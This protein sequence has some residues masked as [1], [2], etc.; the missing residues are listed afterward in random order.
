[1]RLFVALA[2]PED[3][4]QRLHGLQR[5]L[6]AAKWVRPE[7]LHLTLRFIGEV[8]NGQAEDVDAVLSRVGGEPFDLAVGGLG[9][10]G[11]SRKIRA[12]WAGCEVSEPLVRLQAKIERALQVAGLPPEGRKF[13]P[14]I[15]LA[16]FKSAPGS[17][18]EGY[19]E[20]NGGFYHPP[21]PVTGFTL[22]SSYLSQEGALYRPEAEYPFNHAAA[23]SPALHGE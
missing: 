1:M 16:R 14:H 9:Q 20:A 12:L 22:F 10:F 23:L 18:L 17:G 7:S 4:R 5:G 11:D 6:A 21:F 8:D 13:K 19:L 15:T 3:L 2:L